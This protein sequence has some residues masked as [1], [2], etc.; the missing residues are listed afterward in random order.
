MRINDRLLILASNVVIVIGIAL[1]VFGIVRGGSLFIAVGTAGMA[2]TARHKRKFE[3]Y[4][5]LFIAVALFA[6]AIALPRGR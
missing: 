6:L 5:P 1:G 3:F 4:F 2:F